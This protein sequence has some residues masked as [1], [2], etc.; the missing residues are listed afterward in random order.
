MVNILRSDFYR[1]FKSKAFY[2][3]TLIASILIV[4]GAIIMDWANN[5]VSESG[6]VVVTTG[7]GLQ[8]GLSYGRT[9]F[10]GGADVSLFIAIFIAIFIT[11]EFVHGTMKNAV[12]KGFPKY[13]IYLSK[14]I[15]VTA[16]TYIMMLV[17]FVIGTITAG[18]IKGEMG[19]ITGTYVGQMFRMIGIELLLHAALVAILLMVAMTVRS[20][21]GVIAINICIITF[22]GLVYQLLQLL[23]KNKITFSD[24]SLLNNISMYNDLAPVG[25]DILRS[26]LVGVIFLVVATAVGIFAFKKF[27]VK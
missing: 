16:A 15:T 27:D 5:I 25:E 3:C 13:Q 2:I 8:D 6:N 1:L 14:F 26:I 7:I 18:I 10:S 9:A 21:G 23:F 19:E 12:S 20:N 4:I 24:Y 11:A 17:T 22:S